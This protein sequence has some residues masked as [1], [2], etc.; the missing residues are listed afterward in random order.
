[1][2]FLVIGDS[3][4]YGGPVNPADAAALIENVINPSLAMVEKW[5]TEKK[6]VAG[7]LFA[8]QRK[9]MLLVDVPSAEDLHKMLTT[10][11]F[12]GLVKWEVTPLTSVASGIEA[13]SN[14]A[15]GLRSMAGQ[16]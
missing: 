16:H 5:I 15:K 3:V 7:A 13:N 2:K 8:G 9:G 11:P 12:W 1:M 10:L 14:A 4:D 6:V